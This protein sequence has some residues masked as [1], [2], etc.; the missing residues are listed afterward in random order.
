MIR[1]RRGCKNRLISRQALISSFSSVYLPSF[2]HCR[3]GISHMQKT[4]WRTLFLVWVLILSGSVVC[5]AANSLV[6]SQ[7]YTGPLGPYS[8]IELFNQGTSSVSMD[9]WSLQAS[10]P[11][12]DAAWTVAHLSGTV[13]PGQYYLIRVLTNTSR[14]VAP[15]P[16]SDLPGFPIEPAGG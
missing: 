3:S 16:D 1:V 7:I 14:V 6:I 2:T 8:F 13:A 10:A 9:G 15:Q 4:Q 11:D 12:I 5:Q